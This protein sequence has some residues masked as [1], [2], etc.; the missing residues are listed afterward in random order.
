MLWTKPRKKPMQFIKSIDR[1]QR[2]ESSDAISKPRDK[3]RPNEEGNERSESRKKRRFEHKEYL[4]S[5]L[6]PIVM[7]QL[8]DPEYVCALELVVPD[9]GICREAKRVRDSAVRLTT[10][11]L[12]APDQVST[13][14]FT[15]GHEDHILTPVAELR[16]AI[17]K[18]SKMC[19]AEYL[20]AFCR[21]HTHTFSYYAPDFRSSQSSSTRMCPTH[22][23]AREIL[24]YD[25]EMIFGHLPKLEV[26][27]S[28]KGPPI[29]DDLRHIAIHTP[30]CLVENFLPHDDDLY[31]ALALPVY[32]AWSQM[33]KLETV[34]LDLRT[35]SLEKN[36]E[37]RLLS[38]KE[39]AECAREM[40]QHLHLK[41][42][43][44]AG[45]GSQAFDMGYHGIED[46]EVPEAEEID[47][48][49]NWIK[50]FCPALRPGGRIIF[51]DLIAP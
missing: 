25:D 7:E 27:L 44:L 37:F 19:Y 43:L 35:Y 31:S 15:C 1:G 47:G 4:N 6:L 41:L 46:N 45:L 29:Y 38:K 18:I 5:T 49:P 36:T 2:L 50:L 3:K 14:A 8:V 40:G 34:F 13:L 22:R 32:I 20:Q 33:P 24:P 23:K 21:T 28:P 48:Q 16:G 12:G 39:I 42:L 17:M 9:W 10:Y 51:V 11:T 30:L 26:T